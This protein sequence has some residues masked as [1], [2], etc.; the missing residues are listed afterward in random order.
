M[1]PMACLIDIHSIG[2]LPHHAS[3]NETIHHALVSGGVLAIL[4]PGCVCHED[5]K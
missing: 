4:E 5:P 2:L 1:A 3:V